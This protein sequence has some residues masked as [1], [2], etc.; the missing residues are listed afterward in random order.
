MDNALML[1]LQSQRVLQRRMDLAANNLA[2]VSTTGFKADGMLLAEADRTAAHA[3]EDPRDIR[4]VRDIGV[5][6]NMEQGPIA[7][8]GNT[9]DLALEGEGFFMVQ[10]P[11]GQTMYTRDGAFS[12]TGEGRLVTS[13]GYAVLSSGGAPIVIDP[14]GEAPTIG[15]DGAISVAGV[16]AG[17]IGVASFA[18]PGALSKVGDNLWDA[19][20]QAA[21]EFQG[22]VLQGALEGSNVR[23][24]LELTR[25]IEISRAYQSAAKI[26]SGADELRQ[27]A[28]QQLGR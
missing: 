10:G 11:G 12:L 16:E 8:T 14:Q 18:A 2:N 5:M 9:L 7:M 26:V 4:F 17:R 28:I 21:G 1:G 27:R 24:V 25:L 15:R 23:P 22:V 6:H 13:D 19:Q 3:V 20:G